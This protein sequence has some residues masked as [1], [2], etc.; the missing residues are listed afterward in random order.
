M[1]EH[2]RIDP[3]VAEAS[4]LKEQLSEAAN[5]LDS[6]LLKLQRLTEELNRQTQEGEEDVRR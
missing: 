4:R 6:F 2:Q 5:S 3:L 1:M